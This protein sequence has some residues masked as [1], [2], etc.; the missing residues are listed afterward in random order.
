[1]H[2]NEK[3]K[4]IYMGL[5]RDSAMYMFTT[6]S[7]KTDIFKKGSLVFFCH[8]VFIEMFMSL[9]IYSLNDIS[10]HFTIFVHRYGTYKIIKLQIFTFFVHLALGAG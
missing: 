3:K 10:I 9:T 7:S 1:M 8:I 2:D 6:E 4:N 5:G